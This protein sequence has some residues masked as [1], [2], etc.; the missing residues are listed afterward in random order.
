MRAVD[1]LEMSAIEKVRRR[2]VCASP[3]SSFQLG[4]FHVIVN[5]ESVLESTIL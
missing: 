1:A 5:I 3:F 4:A 2:S